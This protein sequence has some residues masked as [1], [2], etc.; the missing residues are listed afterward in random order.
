LHPQYLDPR[1][2][3]ALWR[4]ALLAQAVL[5]GQTRGYRNHPQLDRFK[6]HPDPLVAIS[7]YLMA[8]HTEATARGYHFDRR[9]IGR[10]PAPLTLSV[11]SGQLEHEWAHLMAKLRVR[12]PAHRHRWCKTRCALPHPMFQVI[13]GDVE[14]WERQ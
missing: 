12:D 5:R 13:A 14:P 2:L 9:K 4:E 3:V 6:G 11:T 10:T 1:G 7:A 8:V